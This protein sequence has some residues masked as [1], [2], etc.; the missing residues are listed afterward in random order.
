LPFTI[1]LGFG[2]FGEDDLD[3]GCLLDL[4]HHLGRGDPHLVFA[5]LLFHSFLLFGQMLRSDELSLNLLLA[6]EDVV[7]VRDLDDFGNLARLQ[8]KC[9]PLDIRI[10]QVFA[11]WRNDA[12]GRRHAGLLAVI[13]GNLA[14]R[15]R[16]G[17]RLGPG[18]VG[19]GLARHSDQAGSHAG[20][21][22]GVKGF[23]QL[24]LADG[25]LV[26]GKAAEGQHRPDDFALVLGFAKAPFLLEQRE[27]AGPVEAEAGG[28]AVDFFGDFLVRDLHAT[29][30][31]GFN[32]ELAVDEAFQDFFAVAA[33]ALAAQIGPC[34]L[35]A[36][37]D[38]H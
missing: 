38:R 32:D 18:F 4:L 23:L 7:H 19:L 31:A 5:D 20:A 35:L 1:G 9:N 8:G 2:F 22:F 25:D 37:N 29:G 33:D 34:D 17:N 14:E 12:E 28:N 21:K 24:F 27:P 6:L 15:C 30:L 13:F 16:I 10:A 36:V 11:N 3:L 26:G